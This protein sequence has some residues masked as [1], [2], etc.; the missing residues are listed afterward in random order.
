MNDLPSAVPDVDITMYADDTATDTAFR[1]VDEIKQPL[2]PAFFKLCQWLDKNKLSL[3]IVKTEFMILGT[4]SRLRDLDSDPASTPYIVSVGNIEI[5]RVKS[6]KYLGLIVGDTLSWSDHI[7]HISMKIK[8]SIG[9]LNRTQGYLP[10]SSL[11]TLYR[12]LIETHLRY[13][14]IIWG[15]C[16]GT[17]KALQNRALRT[18]A[19]QKFE[20]ADHSRLL[21]EYGWLSVRN[22]IK[23]DMGI[24]MYKTLNG[25]ALEEFK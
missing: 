25:Q 12:T 16:G 9:V 17:L 23:M 7:D 1:T 8:R 2:L 18:I 3:K 6:T 19:G 13:C 22:L 20:H 24:C 5:K 15:Q 21:A 4:N 11:I 10:K 14:S